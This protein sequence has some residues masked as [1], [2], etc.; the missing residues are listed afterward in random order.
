MAVVK[1]RCAADALLRTFNISM[2]KCGKHNCTTIKYIYNE[3][4]SLIDIC[5]AA[6]D[7]CDR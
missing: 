2:L 1:Q 4:E 5:N 7:S 3:L 6:V